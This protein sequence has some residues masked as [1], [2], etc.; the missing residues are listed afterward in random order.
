MMPNRAYTGGRW[1][2]P[3][4]MRCVELT[5]ALTVLPKS[6]ADRGD[7]EPWRHSRLRWLDST[8]GLDDEVVAP[9][10]PLEVDGR[11]VR[12]LGRE[13]RIGDEG[14]PASIRSGGQEILAQPV[15][16][17]IEADS[18]V[19]PLLGA[20]VK[21]SEQAPGRVVWESY[22]DGGP[23]SLGCRAT[24]EFDG[25]LQYHLTLEAD[26]PVHLKDVRLELPFHREAAAYMMG[27]GRPGGFR[28][29]EYSWKWGGL[30]TAFGSAA[31]ARPA[32]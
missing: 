27:I 28:P 21:V 17:L 4:R 16:F 24:M 1:P 31:S 5:V 13:V 18:G 20:S 25:H 2:F 8:I 29:R 23:I 3:R 22:A 14:L 19:V 32:L 9:Y 26:E 7:S 15:R 6:L 12:C 10:T 11:T 30:R